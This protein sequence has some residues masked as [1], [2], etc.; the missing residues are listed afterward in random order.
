MLDR[1]LNVHPQPTPTPSISGAQ[2]RAALA[3]AEAIIPEGPNVPGADERTV[4]AAEDLLRG[5]S[6][7]HPAVPRVWGSIL[8]MLDQ[9]ARL[10]TGKT[11]ADLSAQEQQALLRRWER[12]PVMRGP[13]HL[14]GFF[15]KFA[16]FDQPHVSE[17]V[18]HQR[19]YAQ[20]ER[21]RWMLEQVIDA[22][23]YTGD[24]VLEC[25]VVV[26]GT[27]AGGA[28]VGAELAALGH[29][30]LFVEE[31]RYHQR[32]AFNQSS[33]QAFKRFYRPQMFSL[34]NAMVPIFAARMV[35][36]STAV[37]TGT[38]W[39]TPDRILDHWCERL[40]T[41]DFSPEA[42]RPHFERVESTLN[43]APTPR[44]F[45][46]PIADLL[47]AGCDAL[48]YSHFTVRRN[49]PGCEGAGFCQLGCP[50]GARSS[51]NLSYVP[52]ALKS[53]AMLMTGLRAESVHLENGRAA[54]INGVAVG[55][56]KQLRVRSKKVVFAGG[57]I[58]T[59]LFLMRQGICNESGQ[60]GR[61]L[62]IHPSTG[63]LGLMEQ[64]VD[65]TKYVPQAYGIDEWTHDGILIMGAGAPA[66]FMPLMFASSGQRF[67]EAVSHIHNMLGLGI[68][69]EDHEP[70]GRVWLERGG[71]PLVTYNL[72]PK[73]V[74]RMHR[75]LV[76]AGEV[77][78][79]AGA[80]RLYPTVHGWNELNTTTDFDAFRKA[81][82]KASQLLLTSYHPL[83]T[84]KMGR[85]RRTSVVDIHHETHEVPGLYIVDGSTVPT[86]P[87]VNPQITIM[88]MATRAAQGIAQ[89][90][91]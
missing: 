28:V 31:G 63:L 4:A 72:H 55:T 46:G 52:Q 43:V 38:C 47:A 12:H 76:G 20:P 16:H 70:N 80:R 81:K 74:E 19:V 27:G 57:A 14:G 42:M 67:T 83:G 65:A 84:C 51:T 78:R 30:V 36:G 21:P 86:A 25:D 69:V 37:N 10:F 87:S 39:R 50:S 60:L 5:L 44:Q 8:R 73:D 77:L 11:F 59:P 66:N 71:Q 23:T 7:D 48:G 33:V 24:D 91:D 34:G 56:G 85:D 2:S 64:R 17:A 6:Q 15:F 22:D 89:R 13:L 29:A 62:S 26:V 3:L 53:G 45:I 1:K 41:D 61:N 79:A 40:A 82:I 35:G 18:G 58:P 49:A 9:S 88:A 90:L 54:G 75:G 68:L 32:D